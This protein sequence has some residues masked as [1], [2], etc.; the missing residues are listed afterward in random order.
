MPTYEYS[1]SNKEC[2][3]K[4]EKVN[5]PM[6]EAKKPIKCPACGKKAPRIPSLPGLIII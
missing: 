4:T 1:C 5:I 2:L 6:S 3:K